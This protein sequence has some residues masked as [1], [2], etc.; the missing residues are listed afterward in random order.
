MKM[1]ELKDIYIALRKRIR[2]YKRLRY[3][4]KKL[5][6]E[7]RLDIENVID[8]LAQEENIKLDKNK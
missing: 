2:H 7:L 4:S 3:P 1:T 6:I 8:L 5:E